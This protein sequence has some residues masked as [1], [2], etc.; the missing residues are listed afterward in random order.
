MYVPTVGTVFFVN[1]AHCSCFSSF[2]TL[3]VSVIYIDVNVVWLKSVCS[4]YFFEPHERICLLHAHGCPSVT[5]EP[6]THNFGTAIALSFPSGV[7]QFLDDQ[8]SKKFLTNCS[9]MKNLPFR[10]TSTVFN[11]R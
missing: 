10:I 9:F 11:L 6:D 8:A 7:E 4:A 3:V 2:T 5:R 1:P